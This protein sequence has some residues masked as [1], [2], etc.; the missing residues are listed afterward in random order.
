[1]SDKQIYKSK[2]ATQSWIGAICVIFFACVSYLIGLPKDLIVSVST[3]IG[4]MFGASVLSQ[5][6]QDTFKKEK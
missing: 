5:G 3:I 6:V 1:M 2:K 4:G